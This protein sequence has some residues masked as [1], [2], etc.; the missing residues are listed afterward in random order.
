MTWPD[1]AVKWTRE[2]IIADAAEAKSLFR[3]RRLGEPLDNYL[4]AFGLLEKANQRLIKEFPRLFADPVDPLL[5]A[6]IVKDEDLLT[7]LR[8]LGAPPISKD[9]LFNPC[10][11]YS[12]MDSHQVRSR[13]GNRGQRHHPGD[14]GPQT[15]PMDL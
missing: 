12:C 4:K 9:D 6:N 14:P 8:Y 5:V 11:G 15:I 13:T 10:R 1:K 2:Q 7:A 3:S